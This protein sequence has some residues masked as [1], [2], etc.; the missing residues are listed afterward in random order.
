[1]FIFVKNNCTNIQ[2][3]RSVIGGCDNTGLQWNETKQEG[4]E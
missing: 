2:V 4:K 3:K 1:M